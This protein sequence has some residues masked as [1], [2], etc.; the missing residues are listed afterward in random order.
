MGRS[1]VEPA[2]V[3]Q[4]PG[5]GLAPDLVWVPLPALEQGRMPVLGRVPVLVRVRELVS[6]QRSV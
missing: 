2:W 5:E 1:P 6:R 4:E 3:E